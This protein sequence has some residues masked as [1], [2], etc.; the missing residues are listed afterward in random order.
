MQYDYQRLFDPQQSSDG[1][2]TAGTTAIGDRAGLG[3]YIHT[4][5]TILATNVALAAGRP[6][7]VRGPS[8]TGK[9][10]LAAS[11][12]RHIGSSYFEIIVTA[13][14]E[15]RDFLWQIDHLRRLRDAQAGEPVGDY[16]LYTKP[17][18]LFWAFDP[19]AA[20]H[21]LRESNRQN[22]TPAGY[23]PEAT[24]ATVLIDEIDK[25]DPDV[26]NSL[27]AA[28]GSHSTLRSWV[29]VSRRRLHRLS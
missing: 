16:A 6:L 17:G 10:S 28:L 4:E 15:A 1:D 24:A 3:G 13:R 8:G 23:K 26:P 11:V 27:L 21:L 12:A 25:A 18:P 2:S 20:A 5:Q 22:L 7:L 14:T 9:S 19:K 29:C